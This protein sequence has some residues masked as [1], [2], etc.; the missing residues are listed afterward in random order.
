MDKPQRRHGCPARPYT[1][2]YGSMPP[3]VPSGRR[4]R[5][6]VVPRLA[7]EKRRTER[8]ARNSRCRSD[9]D[10]EPARRVGRIPLAKSAS[11]A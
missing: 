6:K 9:T 5:W 2:K 7:K 3:I 10:S 4:K 8:I 11:S 1:A